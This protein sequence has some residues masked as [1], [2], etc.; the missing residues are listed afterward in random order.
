[1]CILSTNLGRDGISESGVVEIP[2]KAGSFLGAPVGGRGVVAALGPGGAR[3]RLLD[4]LIPE[5]AAV[6][7]TLMYACLPTVSTLEQGKY[8]C[9]FTN[10]NAYTYCKHRYVWKYI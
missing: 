1:M 6:G 2:L 10:I 8:M 3:Y 7:K 4:H 5:S 9:R